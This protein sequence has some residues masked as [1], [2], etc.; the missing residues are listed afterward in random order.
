MQDSRA[1]AGHFRVKKSAL[2]VQIKTLEKGN[3]GQRVEGQN[4]QTLFED[5]STTSQDSKRSKCGDVL[6]TLSR[7][8]VCDASKLL[9]LVPKFFSLKTNELSLLAVYDVKCWASCVEDPAQQGITVFPTKM[10]APCPD[11]AIVSAGRYFTP[12]FQTVYKITREI[13]SAEV[14]QDCWNKIFPIGVEKQSYIE[15]TS[16]ERKIHARVRQELSNELSARKRR[17]RNIVLV[18]LGYRRLLY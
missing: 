12:S 13:V 5:I 4:L 10:V 16:A 7:K 18:E 6:S 3:R 9:T 2:V 17:S 14:N 8:Y 11:D 1:E 15:A